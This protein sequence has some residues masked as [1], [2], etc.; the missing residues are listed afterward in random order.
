M[1]LGEQLAQT[2]DGLLDLILAATDIDQKQ[3][4]R[5]QLTIVL[6]QTDK[7]VAAN[8]QNNTAEYIAA[9]NG[10]NQANAAITTATNDLTK[11]ADTITKIAKLIDELAKLATSIK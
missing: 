9:T 3:K 2:S 1:T 8:V 5:D 7:L 6:D 11:V 10:L 4:L